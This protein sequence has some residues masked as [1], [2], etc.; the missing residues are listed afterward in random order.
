MDIYDPHASP[1]EVSHEY[2]LSMIT[3]L[4]KRYDAI[5]LTVSHNEFKSLDWPALRHPKTI[6]Y[7]VK[8]VLDKSFIT[9]RL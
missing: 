2:G 6:V 8:G 5:V 7:D 4:E 3:K 9:A 1:E